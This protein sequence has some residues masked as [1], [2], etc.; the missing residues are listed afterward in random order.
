MIVWILYLMSSTDEAF[1]IVGVYS[2]IQNAEA[3]SVAF[4][5]AH[6]EYDE[7]NMFIGRYA[8]DAEV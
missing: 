2:T 6:D 1:E 5:A 7:D 3:A 8:V 4:L